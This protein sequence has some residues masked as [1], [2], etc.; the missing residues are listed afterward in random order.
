MDKAED[1]EKGFFAY[2]IK[3]ILRKNGLFDL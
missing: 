3:C 2:N 1:Y